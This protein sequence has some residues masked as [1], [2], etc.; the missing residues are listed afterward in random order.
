M[1]GNLI[2]HKIPKMEQLSSRVIRILG[3][4]PGPMT[5]QGTNTYLVGTG[6]KRI[7]IDTGESGQEE[8]LTNLT[9]VLHD[10]QCT[11]E[12]IVLTHWH[13]DHVGGAHPVRND[14][15]KGSG[16]SVPLLKFKHSGES[17]VS[18]K[19]ISDGHTFETEGAT[20]RAIH[21]PGHTDDHMSL[22]LC[23]E[24]SL[25]SGDCILGQGTAVF[26]DLF[27]YMKSLEK[28]LTFGASKIYPG[29]GPVIEDGSTK[30][31]EYINHRNMREKQILD[32]LTENGTSQAAS[33]L[34]KKIYKGLADNLVLA[35]EGN[36]T[37]HLTKLEKEGKIRKVEEQLWKSSL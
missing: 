16:E 32:A 6:K 1:A 29:H 4:N 18:Y 20:L 3:C 26:E 28:L 35:A 13:H 25:F 27:D 14:V 23:E 37:H 12:S 15:L 8:Y 17:D 24:N 21:T 33:T 19:H 10:F 7:L 31:A 2:L 9:N 22:Y 36:V 11:I 34:V 5:L 30:I